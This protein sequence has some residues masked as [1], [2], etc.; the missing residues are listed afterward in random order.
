MLVLLSITI[1]TLTFTAKAE[2]DVTGVSLNSSS[3]NIAVGET[4][5]LTA[6]VTPFDATVKAVRFAST[7]PNVKISSPTTGSG[8]ETS[9]VISAGRNAEA[10]IIAISNDGDKVAL[11]QVRVGENLPEG[12]LINR[13]L[14]GTASASSEN[15]PN[16]G[17]S[18]AID[19]LFYRTGTSRS[20]WLALNTRTAWLRVQLPRKYF[21]TKYAIMCGDA[22]VSDMRDP[23]NWQLEGSN[24][25]SDWDVLDI[26]TNEEFIARDFKRVF[27]CKNAQGE[28]PSK[29]YLYYRLNIL[30]SRG[31][32]HIEINE[33]QL[34]ECGP[35]QPWVLGPFEKM[36]DANPILSPNSV[37]RFA[38]PM[39][40]GETSGH[41]W[42]DLSLYNPGAIVKDDMIHLFYRA[43]DTARQ[44]SRVGHATSTNGLIFT[45][46][47]T[48]VL[49]PDNDEFSSLEWPG[50][51]EDPRLI[52]D[53]NGN[54]YMYYTAYNG[55]YAR[56]LVATSNDLM[57]WTKHGHAFGAYADRQTAT[58]RTWIFNQW[59]KAGSVVCEY[60]GERLVA[61]KIN[62]K[63]WMYWGDSTPGAYVATSDDLIN[64]DPV[65]T[66]PRTLKVAVPQR[67]GYFDQVRCE[68]GPAAIY[69]DLGIV[70]IYNGQNNA[71]SGD[72]FLL[73]RA[74][75]PGQVLLDKN[76]PTQ[77]IDRTP[78]YFMYP[79]KDYEMTG[80]VGRVIFV[81]GLTLYKGVYYLY[82]GTADSHL[83]VAVYDPA[84]TVP[85]PKNTITLDKEK[86]SFTTA[87][88]QTIKATV[89]LGGTPGAQV[90]FI[91]T[92][93]KIKLNDV[94]Y[95]PATGE[96][97]AA[98][99]GD[100]T[101][102]GMIIALAADPGSTDA[103]ICNVTIRDANTG[104]VRN[105]AK[106]RAAWHSSAAN[107]D[108]TGHL[109]TDGIYKNQNGPAGPVITQQWNDSPEGEQ[110]VK[111][112][113]G[114]ASTKYLAFH[115]QAWIQYEFPGGEKHAVNGYTITTGNDEA[116]RDPRAW[117]IYGVNDDG[118][119]TPAPLTSQANQGN[120][121][122]GLGARGSTTSKYTFVNT[123]PYKGYRFVVTEN[124]GN[125]Q[126]NTVNS[127][128]GMIQFAELTLYAG[129]VNV[130]TAP[131]QVLESYWQSAAAGSQYVYIDLGGASTFD[132]VNLYWDTANY[133][134]SFQ[135]QV[136]DDAKD[137]SNVVYSTTTGAGGYPQEVTFNTVT[138]RYIRLLC[139]A[140][141]GSAYKLYEFEV[142]GSNDVSV[143]PKPLPA[144][145]ADGRHFLRGGNW[146]LQ[147]ASEVDATGEQLSDTYD[148]SDWA[149]A[150]VPGTVLTS[151][152]NNGS[153]PDPD[154]GDWQFQISDSYFTADF[155]YRD[156][157]PIPSEKSGQ[158][159]WLN[160]NNINWKA[161][162]YFNGKKIGRIEGAFRKGKFDVTDL[163]RFG[164]TN[165]LAVYI[166]KNDNPGAVDPHSQSSA[167]SN[168]G[169]LGTDNPTLHASIGWDW[170]PT[171]R[172]R[173]IGIYGDVFLSYS[174]NVQLADPWMV[175]KLDG[176]GGSAAYNA[177]IDLST[178]HLTFKT[179]VTNSTDSPVSAVVKGVIE[180]GGVTYEQAVNNIPA[181]GTTSVTINLPDISNPRLWWPNRYGE[182]FLYTNTTTVEIGGVVSDTKTF[183]FG[184]R[185]LRYVSSGNAVFTI[186]INGARIYCTGGN[187]GMDESM[188]R[189]D[190]Q[191]Y[192]IA[193]RLHKEAGFTMIRNW[194][195]QT[196]SEAFW[197]ACDKYGILVYD[198]FWLAN[199][200]DGPNPRDNA[201]FM[202]NAYDKIKTSRRHVSVALYCGRNEG[203]PPGG[204][205]NTGTGTSVT[206]PSN[207]NAALRDACAELD[208]TRKYIADSVRTTEGVTVSGGGPY[209]VQTGNNGGP[210]WYF[211]GNSNNAFHTE[212]GMPNIPSMESIRKMMPEED[213]WPVPSRMWGLHDFTTGSAQNGNNFIN[214]MNLYGSTAVANTD[215]YEFVRRAQMVNYEC[216]KAL[217]EAPQVNRSQAMLMWMSHS[218][219]PSMVWHAA[220][221][222]FD[223]NAGY[224]GLKAANQPIN[225]LYDQFNKRIV[226][227]NNCGK[228]YN[229]LRLEVDRYNMNGVK[230][231]N[232]ESVSFNIT[233][234]QAINNLVATPVIAS[235]DTNVNFIQTRVYDSQGELISSNFYWITLAATRSFTELQNLNKI[236]LTTGYSLSKD[237][238]VYTATAQVVNDSDTP[239]L[240]IRVKALTESGEQILPAYFSDNYFSLMP[241]EMKT[242]TVEFDEKHMNGGQ[243]EFYIEGWNVVPAKF[244]EEIPDYTVSQTRFT[245][246]GETIT[247]VTPG[248]IMFEARVT[249]YS[250]AGVVLMPIIAVYKDDKLVEVKMN[251]QPISVEKGRSEWF[252]VGPV[253]LPTSE[254]E[255]YTV[256]GFVWDAD[257]IPVIMDSSLAKWTPGNPNLALKRPVTAS[258]YDGNNPTANLVDG[259]LSSFFRNNDIHTGEEWVYVDLGFEAD[260]EKIVIYAG[261]PFPAS[262]RIGFAGTDGLFSV[263]RTA[264]GTTEVTLTEVLN[265]TIKARYVRIHA[266][267]HSTGGYL[268]QIRE[269]EVYGS[270]PAVG[271]VRLIQPYDVDS[272]VGI[273][274]S[275]KAEPYGYYGT[276]ISLSMDSNLPANAAFDPATGLLSWTPESSQFGVYRVTFRADNGVTTDQKT[277]TINIKPPNIALRKQAY[278]IDSDNADHLPGNAVDGDYTGQ[279][280]WAST[281]GVNKWWY[282]DLGADYDI[283]R[284]V[285]HWEAAYATSFRIDFA[286]AAQGSNG[287]VNGATYTNTVPI[288]QNP[289]TIILGTPRTARYVRFYGLVRATTYGFSFYEFEVYQ[290]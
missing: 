142:I 240:L 116:G 181:G 209:S 118:S 232:T 191:W 2:V 107:Y 193:V 150:T 29:A 76:D 278:A 30:D 220:D 167:G 117:A 175:T 268:M 97:T 242:I 144:P 214:Q 21:I 38:D 148:D 79:E 6:T 25:G 54:Y 41:L 40:P 39:Y 27:E 62:G 3:I 66:A 273:P 45:K 20:K 163:A 100:S 140:S 229:G 211:N 135:I 251:P 172:G 225:A 55:T 210:V 280:R 270:E 233:A 59:S 145:E 121:T 82:Y 285:I 238:S 176:V 197:D 152:L 10:T 56:L 219:W 35:D 123:T 244:G 269:L 9:V 199:P 110:P 63:Y 252:T 103:M 18:R 120:S 189:M 26:R 113:D 129:D 37:D 248:S 196:G 284:I 42:T 215:V 114:L 137:W 237:G 160:F 246:N 198:E 91:S 259:N 122:S 88:P 95:N 257:Y 194:V 243:P 204:T 281:T 22:P 227:S 4:F 84:K 169:V 156:S 13:A 94:S 31:G 277:F 171:I 92:N 71:S 87:A 223:T 141:Q 109:V 44:T 265:P 245:L 119:L 50:G 286:T 255:H 61:K 47:P 53:E 173:D 254:M 253:T 78:T 89:D 60:E 96:T 73:D 205:A 138:A 83:S 77:V 207:L 272:N 165:Y 133:A 147:R 202:E 262:Y 99:S 101:A 250:G 200:A 112:F 19:D 102:T 249:S 234:D 282:V 8:G 190:E 279:S 235:S 15:L 128:R 260:I 46:S 212:R 267:T 266:G 166:Q 230:L 186:Y 174:G 49:Y 224:F 43:Q 149:V 23:K 263:E 68:P 93:D 139:T 184:I 34:F 80:L 216:H 14:G 159:I 208:G 275:V 11:A 24:D 239:V 115:P 178:A 106:N 104:D 180:P 155:W 131:K 203:Q 7:N 86:L 57:N 177:A 69:T 64:W 90:S 157:F 222:Y 161:D 108:N 192:D 124:N 70:L 276:G 185:E 221:Y 48:P 170:V 201:M 274:V 67:N 151:Y 85:I 5:T 153:I 247:S 288:A 261:S 1:S 289:Q 158:K 183:K 290:Q 105:I 134:R 187:W 12:A 52:E 16:E 264:A 132:E 217:I 218:A 65:L 32:P 226:V 256:K 72:R 195:G 81:E 74:Y 17:A 33:F 125:T 36:D 51:C 287:F 127:E 168:G 241:G 228:A 136:S 111:A 126:T 58:D 162:V 130:I 146:K 164:Q 98:V 75:C 179:D 28:A 283:S 143:T 231:R 154:F 206:P 258:S 236:A 188:L 271:E 182:Q 213:L